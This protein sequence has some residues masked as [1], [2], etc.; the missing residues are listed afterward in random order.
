MKWSK[1]LHGV[2]A[3][4]GVAG[5]LVLLLWW[6]V[7][8]RANGLSLMFTPEHLYD[9]ARALLLVSIAFGIGTIIHQHTEKRS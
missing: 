4:S 8:A 2:A 3:I 1:I 5:V 6:I 9:D 7:L